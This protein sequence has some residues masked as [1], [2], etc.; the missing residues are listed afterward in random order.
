MD[1]GIFLKYVIYHTFHVFF[2]APV[3]TF[4]IW[5]G[6][7]FNANLAHNLQIWGIEPVK[8]AGQVPF[9]F[10]QAYIFILF[11]W[12]FYEINHPEEDLEPI[13]WWLHVNFFITC[14][15]RIVVMSVK[16]G[17]F[18][19]AHYEILGKCRLSPE[20]LLGQLILGGIQSDDFD[21][22]K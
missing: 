3:A 18:S 7:G 6:E 22:E 20:F 13:N 4:V 17:Q 14:L 5:V 12:H 15:C 21:F 1:Y 19:D 8:L 9:L 16:Y 2:T 10:V 11:W